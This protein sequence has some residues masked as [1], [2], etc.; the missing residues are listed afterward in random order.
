MQATCDSSMPKCITMNM[1][2]STVVTGIKNHKSIP[3]LC[4]NVMLSATFGRRL[5]GMPESIRIIFWRLESSTRPVKTGNETRRS[6]A[7]R[8]HVKNPRQATVRDASQAKDDTQ[9]SDN[10][11]MLLSHIGSSE[12]RIAAAY[13]TSENGG[14]GYLCNSCDQPIYGMFISARIA[15]ILLVSQST[16]A[17]GCLSRGATHCLKAQVIEVK[18]EKPRRHEYEVLR[19]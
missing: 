7:A 14:T 5:Q 16:S 8:P 9:Y 13:R 15:E 2:Y 6:P 4:T 19:I 11:C 1:P 18:D 12:S 17:A 10:R 3:R